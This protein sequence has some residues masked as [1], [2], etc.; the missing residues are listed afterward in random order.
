MKQVKKFIIAF[1]IPI[2]VFLIGYY[3]L[4]YTIKGENYIISDMQ[5]Q[6]V[7]LFS[8]LRNVLH[9][10]ESILYSFYKGMGGSMFAAFAYYLASPFNLLLLFVSQTNI[11]I[12]IF[13]LIL[14]KIGL[15]SGTMHLYL[16][17]HYK[18][19][20]NITYL[21]STTYALMSYVIQYY[22]NIMWLDAIYL[23]PLV[24]FAIDR[25]IEKNK[26]G[27]YLFVLFFTIV[28][29]FYT[30]YMICIF[31]LFYFLIQMSVQNQKIISK[32]TLHFLICSILA[33]L[34]SSVLLLPTIIEFKDIYRSP[35]GD[36]WNIS[37][38]IRNFEELLSKLYIGSHNCKNVINPNGTNLYCGTFVLVLVYFYFINTDISLKNKILWGS[39]LTF[40]VINSIFPFFIYLWHGFSYPHYFMNRN[41]FLLTFVLILLA[42]KSY[43][44][45]GFVPYKKLFLLY[46]IFGII[47]LIVYLEHYAYLHL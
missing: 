24:L 9:G 37:S 3:A 42:F 20:K 13:I 15:S 26:R 17:N 18:M 7:S 1:C 29:N 2:F 34:S 47:S 40:L 28:S 14:F 27:F 31:S 41:S 33:A 45:L 38:I 39:L 11:P 23:L 21:F 35:M 10:K 19:D 25:L 4:G 6:Y 12:F 16:R 36:L 8:Y 44:Q 46:F 5:G 30:G 32:T 43:N 22:F